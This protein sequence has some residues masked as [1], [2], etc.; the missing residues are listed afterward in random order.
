MCE[1]LFKSTTFAGLTKVSIPSVLKHF[2]RRKRTH[3]LWKKSIHLSSTPPGPC[4]FPPAG[5]ATEVPPETLCSLPSA[6]IQS[7]RC[8]PLHVRGFLPFHYSCIQ[9]RVYSEFTGIYYALALF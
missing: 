1:R 7:G 6:N 3:Y 5:F 4:A 2:S 9:F 8:S